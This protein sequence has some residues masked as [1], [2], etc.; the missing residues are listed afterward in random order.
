M[1]RLEAVTGEP[2]GD[3]L[4][5]VDL[6]P[7]SFFPSIPS[8]TGNGARKADERLDPQ[9]ALASIVRVAG[10]GPSRV[11][12]ELARSKK[13]YTA[14]PQEAMAAV[15]RLKADREMLRKRLLEAMPQLATAA[16]GSAATVELSRVAA[17]VATMEQFVGGPSQDEP[18]GAFALCYRL[19]TVAKVRQQIRTLFFQWIT[20]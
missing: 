8:V 13:G 18:A 12:Q 4:T 11:V 19:C 9:R 1:D 5:P 14:T 6:V 17:A 20:L 2:L 7:A 10:G 3:V 16:K 15:R